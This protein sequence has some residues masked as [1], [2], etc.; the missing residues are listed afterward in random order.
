MSWTSLPGEVGPIRCVE[1]NGP[2]HYMGLNG[3]DGDVEAELRWSKC[4]MRMLETTIA[5]H[6]MQIDGPWQWCS[7]CYE[8]SRRGHRGAAIHSMECPAFHGDGGLK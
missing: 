6:E 4:R 7:F 1:C 2:P 8:R 5:T 3:F